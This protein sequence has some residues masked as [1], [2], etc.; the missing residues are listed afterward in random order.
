[1][2]IY[3]FKRVRRFVELFLPYMTVKRSQLEL[4][5]NFIQSRLPKTYRYGKKRLGEHGKIEGDDPYSN[6]EWAM[7][8]KIK[9]LNRPCDFT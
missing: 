3:G 2:E 9:R 8:E 5:H 4:L 7:V 6:E 1:M